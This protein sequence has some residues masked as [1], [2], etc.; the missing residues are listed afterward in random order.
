MTPNPDFKVTIFSTSN[1][2]T[3]VNIHTSNLVVGTLIYITKYQHKQ[4]KLTLKG[5]VVWVT[6][7]LF[8]KFG[9]SSISLK[10]MK[11][12][13]PLPLGQLYNTIYNFIN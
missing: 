5:G 2:P 8:L 10:R 7:D 11:I 6:C 12:Q 9:H 1:D 13:L 3:T 4:R